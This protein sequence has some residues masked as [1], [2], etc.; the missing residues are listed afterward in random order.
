MVPQAWVKNPVYANPS[1]PKEGMQSV[2]GKRR[3]F[4]LHEK[5]EKN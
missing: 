1:I 2:T 3:T 5:G 4:A